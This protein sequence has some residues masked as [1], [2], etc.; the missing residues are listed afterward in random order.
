M[1]R[2][3]RR[4]R[5]LPAVALLAAGVAHGGD[6]S[7]QNDLMPVLSERCVMCHMDGADQAHLSLFPD[8]WSH[9]VGIASTEATLKRVEAGV[10][11]KSYLYLK[12]LGTQMEGGGRG[13]RMPFQQDPLSAE[14]LALIKTWIAQGA[15]QN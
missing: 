8:A 10:P 1:K 4:R 5:G 6:V 11:D 9:L 14:E 3:A 7:F 2:P 12:L 13:L 15:L